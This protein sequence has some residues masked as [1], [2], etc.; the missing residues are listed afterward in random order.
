MW[1]GIA[2]LENR[3][4]DIDSRRKVWLKNFISVYE[5]HLSYPELAI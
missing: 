5:L 2:L 4:P 3:C 1:S